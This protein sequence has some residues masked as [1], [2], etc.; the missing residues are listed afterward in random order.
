[1]EKRKT[2]EQNRKIKP[3]YMESEI[4]KILMQ[5]PKICRSSIQC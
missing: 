3:A 2:E 5:N 4:K 1:M